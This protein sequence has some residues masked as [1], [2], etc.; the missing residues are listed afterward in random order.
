MAELRSHQALCNTAVT[1]DGVRRLRGDAD[2]RC[3]S[4]STGAAPEMSRK[5]SASK[6]GVINAI[7]KTKPRPRSSYAGKHQK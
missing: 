4:Q 1:Q 6:S 5:I 7:K 3:D 2:A